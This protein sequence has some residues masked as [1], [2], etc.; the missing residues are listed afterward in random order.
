MTNR[1]CPLDDRPSAAPVLRLGIAAVLLSGLLAACSGA[2]VSYDGVESTT[3]TPQGRFE[4][5]V[6]DPNRQT[7]FGAGGINSLFSETRTNES[8]GAGLGVNAFLWRAS[9]DTFAFLPPI[10]ADPLGGVIIYD[11]Y[12]SPETPNERFKVTVYILDTRLR[13]D[14]VQV[15]VNRQL[16]GADGSWY[17]AA[18]DPATP[19]AL[20]DAI[21]TRAR[22]MRIAQLGQ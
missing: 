1:S 2:D 3:Q 19:A 8:G 4:P 5:D 15:Q 22:Q 12:A 9:L 16:R 7:I 20:V 18:V 21:L 14:G 11:W 6:N 13:A 10:S 17:E